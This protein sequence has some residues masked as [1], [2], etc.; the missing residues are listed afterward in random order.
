MLCPNC[1]TNLPD[2]ATMC[3]ACKRTIVRKEGRKVSSDNDGN[4]V[5]ALPVG[6]ILAERYQIGEII[7]QGG[8]GIT[9]AGTDLKLK[10]K[11]AIKEYYPSGLANRISTHSFD[12]TVAR[13]DSK[14][15]Y[16]RERQKFV[17]E[18]YILAGFAGDRNVVSVMDIILEH[19]TAYIVMEFLDGQTLLQFLRQN[20]KM[21]FTAVITMLLPVIRTLGRIH[22]NGLIHRDISPDNIMIDTQGNVILM[23]FGSAREFIEEEERS[24]T[25][26]L[27]HGYA[28]PEQYQRKGDQGTWTDVYAICATIYKMIT[29]VTPPD[30]M[31]RVINDPLKRPGELGAEINAAQEKVLLWGM[32]PVKEDRIRSMDQLE[33]ELNNTIRQTKMVW[34][35]S[36]EKP[37]EKIATYRTDYQQQEVKAEKEQYV[38]SSQNEGKKAEKEAAKQSKKTK[39]VIAITAAAIV[40]AAAIVLVIVFTSKG[41]DGGTA[42]AKKDTTTAATSVTEVPATAADT[43]ADT[44]KISAKAGDII[45]FG[46]YE[47]DNNTG[48]GAEP[49]SWRVLDVEEGRL[50][51]ISEKALD[52][53]KYN[54]EL[55]DVTWKTCT[56]RSW[57]NGDFYEKAFTADERAKILMTTVANRDNNVFGTPGGEETYDHI[58]LLSIDETAKYFNMTPDVEYEWRPYVGDDSCSKSTD[59]AVANGAYTYKWDEKKAD[60]KKYD[61]N[62]WWWLRSPGQTS[63]SVSSISYSGGLNAGGHYVNEEGAAIR[64]AMWIEQ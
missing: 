4:P 45:T 21:P 62:N 44:T 57:L 8:F 5:F 34:N 13:H 63:D 30:A 28:P 54:E 12:V 40:V 42:G 37:T 22:E 52:S 61:G 11:V 3:Y 20:G 10:K 23:D 55:A 7:G 60:Y 6:S 50:L 35:P 51:V 17:R 43:T 39:L 53:K 32:N 64:P 14:A 59:H 15:A 16:E 18:A 26:V 38:V 36:G 19:N 56:L 9:Y 41:S 24:M 1:G 2:T 46:S 27:K 49:I 58:F 47:Q 31:D 48:N 25:V 33:R 29:G